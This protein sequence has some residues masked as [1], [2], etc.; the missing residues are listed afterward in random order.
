MYEIVGLWCS[1]NKICAGSETI[2]G[3][4]LCTWQQF[5]KT[6]ITSTISTNIGENLYQDDLFG[7]SKSPGQPQ[8]NNRL[9][10]YSEKTVIPE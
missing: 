9:T 4:Y 3:T 6:F 1:Q 8:N 2:V 7:L 10:E 5:C